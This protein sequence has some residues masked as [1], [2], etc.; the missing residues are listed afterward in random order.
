[1]KDIVVEW[2]EYCDLN[3]IKPWE[4][5]F[6]N[7]VL[8][9]GNSL[10]Q[11]PI[12]SIFEWYINKSN[13]FLVGVEI[14]NTDLASE[15]YRLLWEINEDAMSKKR[16]SLDRDVMNSFWNIYK[17]DIKLSYGLY[18][19]KWSDNKI[20]EKA[21]QFLIDNYP[22]YISTNNR[23]FLYSKYTHTIG[24]FIIE[25]K[26]FNM[27]RKQ[28]DYWDLALKLLYDFFKIMDKDV[29]IKFIDTF[30]LH[31]FV[32]SDYSLSYYWDRNN[33]DLGPNN[34]EEIVRFLRISTKSIEQRGKQMIKKICED[35]N[36]IEYKFYKNYL[37]DLEV[38]YAEDIKKE[39]EEELSNAE[40][41]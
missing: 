10:N 21:I 3:G 23:I 15:I 24:N 16:S 34:E 13:K 9:E 35:K 25:T 39:F 18:L 1:M 20:N 27:G 12:V 41:K 38:K 22:T 29:W 33:N 37:V 14:E 5:D 31:S 17:A 40:S 28:N 32:N 4:Y 7:E 19:N 11:N 2:L 36:K 26:G 8:I 6:K 30:M